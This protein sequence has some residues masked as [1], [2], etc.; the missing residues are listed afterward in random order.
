M[1]DLA[2]LVNRYAGAK[3]LDK[4]IPTAKERGLM[5]FAPRL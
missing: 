1:E 4:G 3:I 2:G 5:I